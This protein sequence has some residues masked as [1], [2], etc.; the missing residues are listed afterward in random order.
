MSPSLCLIAN[1]E[2]HNC[3]ISTTTAKGHDK[4]LAETRK[5]C[6]PKS[7]D[8]CCFLAPIS[9]CKK[10]PLG[11]FSKIIPKK[12]LKTSD[13]ILDSRADQCWDSWLSINDGWGC[14]CAKQRLLKTG[15]W[16]VA[17]FGL[18]QQESSCTTPPNLHEPKCLGL[19]GEGSTG[20]AAE[21][22]Q[23]FVSDVNS[24]FVLNRTATS[25]F[26][27]VHDTVSASHEL[28]KVHASFGSSF[29]R[30]LEWWRVRVLL[31]YAMCQIGK[32]DARPLEKEQPQISN[33]MFQTRNRGGHETAVT[34]SVP[35][36][37]MWTSQLP[38][39]RWESENNSRNLFVKAVVNSCAVRPLNFGGIIG[40]PFETLRQNVG[41]PQH[42]NSPNWVKSANVVCCTPAGFTHQSTRDWVGGYL[43]FLRASASREEAFRGLI[44]QVNCP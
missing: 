19:Q 34:K 40:A 3:H 23:G 26:L 17:E 5:H 42:R 12:E 4:P 15:F 7:Y 22:S 29:V 35:S 44:L 36:L 30:I 16:R 14:F 8:W 10:K 43:K 28:R 21:F 33:N 31:H 9:D 27:N 2:I 20:N 25:T 41:A 18:L 38:L 11:I 13:W 39:P 24:R 6:L 32:G 37:N 1:L